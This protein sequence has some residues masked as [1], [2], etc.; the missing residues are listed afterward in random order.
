MRRALSLFGAVLV[1]LPSGL[2]AQTQRDLNERGGAALHRADSTLNAVYAQ[3]VATYRSDTVAL[4]KLRAAQHAWLVFR[5]AQVE[6]TYPAVERQKAYGSV[7]P[8]CISGLLEELTK[9]RV[10][11]L[12]RSLRPQEGDVC[13]S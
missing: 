6:A 10:A 13:S 8:M 9:A 2:D 12:R 11:Q 3:L 4:R 5:D 7:L 1:L